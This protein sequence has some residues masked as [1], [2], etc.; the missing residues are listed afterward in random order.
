MAALYPLIR[1]WVEGDCARTSWSSCAS[2]S[3]RSARR[4]PNRWRRDNMFI[5]GDAAHLTP[6][7][8]GQG[9]CAGLRDAMNLAWKLA[10][11]VNGWLPERVLDTYEQ[12]R[13]PHARYM[14]RFALA[15]GTAMTAGGEA[16][17]LLR[18]VV[19]P[20]LHL[21]PGMR[22]KIVDSTTPALHGSE[23]VL[24]SPQ[25]TPTC[26]PAVPEPHPGRRP[27]SRHSR[28]PQ[29]RRD[30]FHSAQP[31]PAR[32]DDAPRR[33]RGDSASRH[34]TGVVAASRSG[35]GRGGAT[36][37]DG[38]VRGPRYRRGCR[39]STGF[40]P[41]LPGPMPRPDDIPAHGGN[42]YSPRAILDPHPHYARLHRL[43]P[44]A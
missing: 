24:K 21:I 36:G 11:V 7:F 33:R 35:Q 43:G 6:P 5:L 19:V 39:Q 40:G 28:R 31:V 17:N 23:L 25:T 4:W 34:R 32:R 38:D 8:I 22:E 2:P 12:E 42:L 30:H 37:P 20:R 15:M 16:G 9:L 3:T 14:I 41:L 10:G 26:G 13:M 27:T 1:P 29:F 18:R 44:V